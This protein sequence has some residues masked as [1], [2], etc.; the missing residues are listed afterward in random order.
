MPEAETSCCGCTS[1]PCCCLHPTSTGTGGKENLH[2]PLLITQSVS[3]N[4]NAENGASN[5]ISTLVSNGVLD[6][7]SAKVSPWILG[8][9]I[10]LFTPP[11]SFSIDVTFRRT[12]FAHGQ[13][14]SNFSDLVIKKSSAC[15][16]WSVKSQRA[17]LSL[18]ACR[19]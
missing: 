14:A 3:N 2:R 19:S 10:A 5:T 7:S 11:L 16:T 13:G 18:R 12:V 6:E 17:S 4:K 1:P 15:A 8:L 9:M